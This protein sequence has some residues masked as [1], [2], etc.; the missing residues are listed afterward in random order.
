[1][2][3]TG[4]GGTRTEEAFTPY[5][6]AL[7]ACEMLRREGR[8][9]DTPLV[10]EPSA[11]K[12]A[13]VHA[14]KDT[15]TEPVITALDVKITPSL[16]RMRGY[17]TQVLK[18]DFLTYRGRRRY[19]LV[20]G[21]PPYGPMGTN[22]AEKHTR[23]AIE[24]LAPDGLLVF[25]LRLNFLAGIERTAGLWYEHPPAMVLPLDKRPSFRKVTHIDENGKKKT[26]SSDACEYGLFLFRKNPTCDP[27]VIQWLRWSSYLQDYEHTAIKKVKK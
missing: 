1:M 6:L 3:A 17:H 11:G 23:R 20:I 24:F 25:L 14:V 12:G 7:A 10:L 8:V 9:P 26:S 21:N 5:P 16:R 4:R 22:N 15:W 13:F 2:S 19:D 27:P 18:R